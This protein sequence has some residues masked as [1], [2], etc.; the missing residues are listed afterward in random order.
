MRTTILI[1]SM[2]LTTAI[3]GQSYEVRVHD[4]PNEYAPNEPSICINR[5]NIEQLTG[6]ANIYNHYFSNDAGKSWTR[7][8]L[9]SSYGV[10]GDPVLHSDIDGHIYFLHLARTKGKNRNYGFIDR[11]VIQTSTDGGKTFNNGAYA[12]FN[13]DKVQDKP[14]I[15]TDDYS[16]ERKGNAYIT[17]TEFDQY[18]SKSKDHHSRIQFSKSTDK[19][20]TW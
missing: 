1:I 11:I 20:T 4:N 12:G 7:N 10:W 14:W 5:A 9:R 3:F 18:G 13:G 15:S 17:W 8:Q 2:L 19:G 16:S 6:G